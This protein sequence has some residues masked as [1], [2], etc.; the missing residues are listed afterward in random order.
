MRRRETRRPC[1]CSPKNARSCP[2]CTQA[3][4]KCVEEAWYSR[5]AKKNKAKS[6]QGMSTTETFSQKRRI[7]NAR[8][9]PLGAYNDF[10][11]RL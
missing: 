10:G 3:W 9:S 8:D 5:E 4:L 11:L 7:E 2:K 1:K 6:K